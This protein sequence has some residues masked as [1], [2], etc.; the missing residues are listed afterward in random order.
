M[1]DPKRV[2]LCKEC[3]HLC[4]VVDDGECMGRATKSERQSIYDK[5]AW[6][7]LNNTHKVQ[8]DPEKM[9]LPSSE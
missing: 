8:P 6:M 2:P 7:W 3:D 5:L 1:A 9:M 4:E